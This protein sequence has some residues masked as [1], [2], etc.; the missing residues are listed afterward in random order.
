VSRLDDPIAQ[1]AV[2]KAWATAGEQPAAACDLA[3]W[4]LVRPPAVYGIRASII[5]MDA[6]RA[7]TRA[8][9]REKARAAAKRGLSIL[10]S[11]DTDGLRLELLLAMHEAVPDERVL[12]AAGQVARRIVRNLPPVVATGFSRRPDVAAALAATR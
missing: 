6:A 7:L 9:D 2:L 1:Y 4:A 10:E 5:C 8:G 12:A 3:L 11:P